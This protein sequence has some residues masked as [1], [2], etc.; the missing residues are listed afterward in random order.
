[1]NE[2]MRL[3]HTHSLMHQRTVSEHWLGVVDQPMD[4]IHAQCMQSCYCITHVKVCDQGFRP[5]ILHCFQDAS[6]TRDQW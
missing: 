3:I 5:I 2:W 4:C 6:K 1:M